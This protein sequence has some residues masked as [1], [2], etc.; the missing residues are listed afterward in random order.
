MVPTAPGQAGGVD[1][2]ARGEPEARRHYRL[3]RRAAADHPARLHQI[4]TRDTM[5]DAIIPAACKRL[6]SCVHDGVDIQRGDVAVDER[7]AC[8]GLH[9]SVQAAASSAAPKRRPTYFARSRMLPS[10]WA[11]E[12]GPG[13]WCADL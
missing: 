8:L 3:A 11:G 10:R 6:V 9:P 7:D 4:G 1:D 13:V 12:S 2:V 5:D